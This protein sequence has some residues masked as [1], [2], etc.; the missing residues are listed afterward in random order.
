MSFANVS[1]ASLEDELSKNCR[2]CW[3]DAGT[4]I[5]TG[6]FPPQIEHELTWYPVLTAYSR[7]CKGAESLKSVNGWR[8]GI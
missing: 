1:V 7:P 5:P 4:A 3:I 6:T 8:L 2:F